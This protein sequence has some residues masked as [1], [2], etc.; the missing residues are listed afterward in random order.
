MIVVESSQGVDRIIEF[1]SKLVEFVQ[2]PGDMDQYLSKIR[3]DPPVSS[4][5][6]V[7]Q[8]AAW[9]TTTEAHVIKLALHR[10]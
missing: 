7:G 6:C 1:D 8:G 9:N 5:V 4:F 2:T 10:I 3:I